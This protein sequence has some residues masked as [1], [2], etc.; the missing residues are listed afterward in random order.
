MYSVEKSELL[1]EIS[2]PVIYGCKD[3]I[4]SNSGFNVSW[5]QYKF[6][7]SLGFNFFTTSSFVTW[8]F[9]LSHHTFYF[10][11]FFV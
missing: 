2:I 5:S 4:W 3:V 9:F 7:F 11:D 1:E 6:P 8:K 10:V